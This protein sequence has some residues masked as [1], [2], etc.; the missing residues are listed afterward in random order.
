M[1][2]GAGSLA[3]SRIQVLAKPG[4]LSLKEILKRLEEQAI[5]PIGI[6]DATE[7]SMGW[8]HPHSGEPDFADARDWVTGEYLMFGLRHDQKK[9]PGTLYRLQLRQLLAEIE[10]GGAGKGGRKGRGDDEKSEQSTRTMRDR[11]KERVK[12]ELLKRTLP[13][14]RLS[15]VVWQLES[16]EIWIAS[17]SSSVFQ[18]FDACFVKSFGL[19]YVMKNPGI[20]GIDFASA[21]ADV[22]S[23]DRDID[24]L[25]QAVPWGA[26]AESATE[27]AGVNGHADSAEEE[28]PF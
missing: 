11:A 17:S 5:Q 13:S 7:E 22:K 15:E 16:N 6:E 18:A 26:F 2:I 20:L 12:L 24:K 8:C 10:R 28:A 21:F 25:T 3:L 14:I 23:A 19:P 9:I 4:S 27:H 1:S